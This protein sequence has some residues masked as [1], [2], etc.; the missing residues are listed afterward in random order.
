[1]KNN[2]IYLFTNSF[3]FDQQYTELSFLTNEV[4]ILTKHFSLTIFPISNC[5]KVAYVNNDVTINESLAYELKQSKKDNFFKKFRAAGSYKYLRYELVNCNTVHQFYNLIVN[6]YQIMNVYRWANNNP[7]L[8]E[9]SRPAILYTYWNTNITLGLSYFLENKRV[10]HKLIS[11]AHGAD[12]YYERRRFNPYYSLRLTQLDALYLVSRFGKIYLS[13]KFPESKNKYHVSYLGTSNGKHI[14]HNK[15]KSDITIA[16]C[17]T[18]NRIKRVDLIYKSIQLFASNHKEF[19]IKWRHMGGGPLE[20]KIKYLIKKSD[21]RNMDVEITGIILNKDI[22]KYYRNN[23]V[24]CFI[25][26]SK[27]EGLPVAIMESQSYG[28]PTIAPRVGGIPEIVNS[29]NGILVD[30]RGDVQEISSAIERIILN[31]DLRQKLSRNAYQNWKENFNADKNYKNFANC[32]YK[33][34][35]A[36]IY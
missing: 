33:M 20:L 5:G 3:P 30:A 29:Q 19:N 26:T 34:L 24:D 25:N 27:T 16:S 10:S 6:T 13:N 1:M 4:D 23:Y 15:A 36:E 35:N 28:I 11:R 9:Q 8:F 2:I 31:K 22:H 17:S 21:L 12:L 7:G 14:I 18:I 32:L